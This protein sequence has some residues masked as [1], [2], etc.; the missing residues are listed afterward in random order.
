MS[1]LQPIYLYH[2][3]DL[4]SNLEQ[5]PAAVSYVKEC[6]R[7][8]DKKEETALFFDLGDHADRVHPVT[9]AT[10]GKGNVALLNQG[11]IH[12]AAIGNNEGITLS[13]VELEALYE[14]AEFTVLLANLFDENGHLPAWAR[15]YD[16]VETKEGVRIGL[17]GMTVPFYP[18]YRELGWDVRDPLDILPG[19]AA[20]VK[21]QADAVVLLSHLG[22]PQD[23]EIARTYSDID[24]ILGAHTHHL[25]KTS[26]LQNDTLIAQC[27]KSGYYAGQVKLEFDKE[28]KQL[29]NKEGA[30]VD[31]SKEEPDSGTNHLLQQLKKDAEATMNHA[32]AFMEEPL[33]VS[34]T[35]ESPFADKLAQGL[36]EWCG[37]EISMVNSGL[38]LKSLPS[39]TV[40]RADLHRLCPHPINPCVLP[41]PGAVLKETISAAFTEKMIHLPVKGLGFRG[42]VLGRMAFSGMDIVWEKNGTREQIKD[43]QIHGES[44]DPKRTY[45]L[46]TADMFTFGPLFPG[47]AHC[48]PKTYYMPEMM[49]DV[50]AFALKHK[51]G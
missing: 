17:I 16:I 15:P 37:A 14:E 20:E 51:E 10:R 19:L 8:H 6:A 5:W 48:G 24:V 41:V 1:S 25:L 40:R 50:L 32:V 36:R 46:A 3:N 47:L 42:E 34:W 49:R 26:I 33:P 27:G 29:I 43:I 30:A 39:G 7:F 44:L 38:L 23:E 22:Y 21:Q 35:D 9:E 12:Y 45:Q 13:K 4:H 31:I 28:T 18:F 2:T 11:G